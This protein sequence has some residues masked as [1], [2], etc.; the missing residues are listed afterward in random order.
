MLASWYDRIIRYMIYTMQQHCREIEEIL[1]ARI[2]TRFIYALVALFS[3]IKCLRVEPSAFTPKTYIYYYIYIHVRLQGTS[4]VH[5]LCI[6][7]PI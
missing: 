7:L 6:F 4:I 2:K 1:V 3:I 5:L